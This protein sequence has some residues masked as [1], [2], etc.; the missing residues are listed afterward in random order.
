MALAQEALQKVQAARLGPVG[1]FLG[2]RHLGRHQVLGPRYLLQALQAVS[3]THLTL[4]T[5]PY[6]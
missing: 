2:P 1:V 5:T 3:Y 4:P 6:V